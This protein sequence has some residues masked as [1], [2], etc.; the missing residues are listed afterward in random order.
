MLVSAEL[1]LGMAAPG[2]N[3]THHERAIDADFVIPY[4]DK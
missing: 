2:G 4:S 1:M 3:G